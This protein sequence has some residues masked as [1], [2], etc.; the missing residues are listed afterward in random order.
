MPSSP[1]TMSPS[2][3]RSVPVTLNRPASPC[4]SANGG[5]ADGSLGSLPGGTVG[6]RP[7]LSPLACNPT[8]TRA[9]APAISVRD[10][11]GGTVI[12]TSR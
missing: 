3:P 1:T 12:V 8:P 6:G 4:D 2:A 5:G 7:E 9:T 11:S 10:A